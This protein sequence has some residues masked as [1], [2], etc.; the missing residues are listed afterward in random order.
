M[1]RLDSIKFGAPLGTVVPNTSYPYLS[2]VLS[3]NSGA[4]LENKSVLSQTGIIGVKSII[5][6]HL[7]QKA[8][9]EVSA[10]CLKDQYFNSININTIDRVLDAVTSTGALKIKKNDVLDHAEIYKADITSNVK[11]EY[12]NNQILDSLLLLKTNSKYQV[13]Q[14]RQRGNKGIV[15]NNKARTFKERLIAYHKSTEIVKDKELREQP[16]YG[17]I[18]KDFTNVWRFEQNT[19]Q[20]KKIRERFNVSDNRLMSVLLSEVNPNLFLFNKVLKTDIQLDLFSEY[21]TLGKFQDLRYRLGDETIIERCNYDIQII[22][23][24]LQKWFKSRDKILKFRTHYSKLI[25]EIQ[26]EK[27]N[28]TGINQ[29]EIIQAIQEGLKAA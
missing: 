3:D 4:Q 13:D 8:V 21:E 7:N 15:F 11:L 29:V 14:Y 27:A 18:Q 12:T 16:Y 24:L 6:D 2:R 28:K 19:T 17:K 5:I 9:V 25:R 26:I 10:K 20:L 1:V 22:E 23:G